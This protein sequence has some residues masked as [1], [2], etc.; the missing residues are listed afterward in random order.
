[1]SMDGSTRRE[2]VKVS[3]NGKLLEPVNVLRKWKLKIP[4]ARPKR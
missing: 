1:M 3:R 4:S 2:A